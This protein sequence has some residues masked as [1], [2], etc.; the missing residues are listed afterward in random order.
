MGV[1]GKKEEIRPRRLRG[2]LRNDLVGL[3]RLR[4]DQLIRIRLRTGLSAAVAAFRQ[5]TGGFLP[6][7]FPQARPLAGIQQP[8][9]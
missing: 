2:K 1:G 8:G 7:G 5:K 3:L 4:P 6:V 9:L